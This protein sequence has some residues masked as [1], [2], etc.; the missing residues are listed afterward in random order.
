MQWAIQL[1]Q[2]LKYYFII[3]LEIKK[4]LLW[5]GGYPQKLELLINLDSSYSTSYH[6]P[7]KKITP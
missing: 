3:N 4:S 7:I 1:F 6:F 5:W 2:K